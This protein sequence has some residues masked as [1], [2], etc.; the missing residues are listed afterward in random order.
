[1]LPKKVSRLRL[2]VY[3]CRMRSI[4]EIQTEIKE[5]IAGELHLKVDD[6]DN[7]KSFHDMGLDS[8]NSIFLLAKME[9]RLNVHIDPMS[10]YDNPTIQSFSE[11]IYSLIK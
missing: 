4:L 8:V 11:Y 2:N 10:V 5:V 1:M 7:T 9:E 6:M 3:I